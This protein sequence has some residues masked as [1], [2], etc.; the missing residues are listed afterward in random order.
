MMMYWWVIVLVILVLGIWIY[1]G[2][3]VLKRKQN[4]MDIQD[5]RFAKAEISKEE[6]EERK[7]AINSKK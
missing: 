2:K 7:Q 4:P 1:A 3:N 6:Y 5:E